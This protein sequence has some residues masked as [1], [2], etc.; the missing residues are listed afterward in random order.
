MLRLKM[1][2]I[3]CFCVE[4]M[5][6]ALIAYYNLCTFSCDELKKPFQIHIQCVLAV[7]KLLCSCM[8]LCH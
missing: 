1:Y 7:K 2:F 8:I 4:G 3:V 5:T 6:S